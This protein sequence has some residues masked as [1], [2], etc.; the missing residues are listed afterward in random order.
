M[1]SALGC[2]VRGSSVWELR[3][4]TTNCSITLEAV[5]V[6]QVIHRVYLRVQF[7]IIHQIS[8]GSE[9]AVESPWINNH[10]SLVHVPQVREAPQQPHCARFSQV[11]IQELFTKP[12]V[13][14]PFQA[15]SL[16]QPFPALELPWW[17]HGQPAAPSHCGV[18][19]CP[20]LGQGFISKPQECRCIN[21]SGY[22]P[23]S[24]KAS[25]PPGPRPGKYSCSEQC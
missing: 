23:L 11:S 22:V 3:I 4:Y 20:S 12:H 2:G 5:P 1:F 17:F 21:M 19:W 14:L 13:L 25:F 10:R 16:V 9:R 8:A 24:P 7:Q 15:G 18:F 6:C